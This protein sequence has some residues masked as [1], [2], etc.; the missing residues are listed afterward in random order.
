M[1]MLKMRTPNGVQWNLTKINIRY[2][3]IERDRIE[4]VELCDGSDPDYI[5]F[6]NWAKQNQT[7]LR[8]THHLELYQKYKEAF[9]EFGEILKEFYSGIISQVE[10]ENLGQACCKTCY[11]SS[12]DRYDSNNFWYVCFLDWQIKGVY[13][14]V[15]PTDSCIDIK[16]RNSFPMKVTLHY[17]SKEENRTKIFPAGSYD[18]LNIKTCFESSILDVEQKSKRCA[19]H[20]ARLQHILPEMYND[21]TLSNIARDIFNLPFSRK[22]IA[23]QANEFED[24]VKSQVKDYL[25][26]LPTI[27]KFRYKNEQWFRFKRMDCFCYD[28]NCVQTYV[29]EIFTWREI[30]E[31]SIQAQDYQFLLNIAGYENVK[32][33]LITKRSQ[34]DENFIEGNSKH[35]IPLYTP[36]GFLS[37]VRNGEIA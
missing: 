33:L 9:D 6:L 27:L 14:K 22:C 32:P 1:A 12:P 21:F 26:I 37:K 30:E 2:K 16:P 35:G 13:R 3:P 24:D 7:K 36:E 8:S 10:L 31:K 5:S 20:Y 28:S 17:T 23:Q 19:W 15:K 25:Q 34:Y 18:P 11:K 4:S 29:L